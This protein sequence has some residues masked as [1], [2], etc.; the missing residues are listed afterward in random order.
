MTQNAI[1]H[2]RIYKKFVRGGPTLTSFFLVDQGK[3]DQN[4]TKSGPLPAHQRN[5]IMAFRWRADDGPT[6]NAGFIFTGSGLVLKINPIFL[7]PSLDP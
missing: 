5:A 1:D 2:V 4:I 6:L 7:S 3:E